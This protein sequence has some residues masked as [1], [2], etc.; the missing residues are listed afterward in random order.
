MPPKVSIAIP[1]YNNEKYLRSCL[2]SAVNQ[3]LHNIEVVLV[4]DCSTDSAYLIAQEYGNAIRLYQNTTNLGECENTNRCLELC[5]GEYV[6]ILHADDELLPEFAERLSSV[7]DTY[8][9]VNIVCGEREEIDANNNVHELAPFYDDSYLIPGIKQAKV[10]MFTTF[11]FC[12][13]M[14]RRSAL[15]TLGKFRE[16]A[17]PDGLLGF[18]LCLNSPQ[19]AYIRDIV[20]KYRLHDETATKKLF[21]ESM[22]GVNGLYRTHCEMV[23]RAGDN[24]YI[25]QFKDA[26]RKRIGQIALRYCSDAISINDRDYIQRY[27]HLALSFDLDLV[28]NELYTR[29]YQS[30]NQNEDSPENFF[31]NLTSNNEQTYS[32]GRTF[33]Y[34][35]PEGAVSFQL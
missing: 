27:L 1:S 7:L 34:D 30:V 4:D 17:N 18:T 19:F 24:E 32:S 26:A 35:P 15:E 12:Q 2:E 5:E 16:F 20:S 13:S 22:Y 9:D 11:V 6:T 29:I 23:R 3:T 10:F 14:Y 8:K 33:S 21:V 31:A 25:A 28:S